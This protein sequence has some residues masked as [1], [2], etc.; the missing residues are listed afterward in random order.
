MS[1][2]AQINNNRSAATDYTAKKN[3]P[4]SGGGFDDV[5]KTQADKSAQTGAENAE[6]TQDADYR[7]QL[8]E[9]MEEMADRI[10]HGTIQPKIRIGAQEYTQE[11]WKKMLEKFDDAEETLQEQIREEIENLKEQAEKEELARQ[12]AAEKKMRAGEEKAVDSAAS[13]ML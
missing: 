11:E 8:Q 2:Y 10:R 7:K 3:A 12:I 5:L 13:Y 9:H 6:S 4:K 1:D